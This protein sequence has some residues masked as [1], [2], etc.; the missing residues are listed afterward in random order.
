MVTGWPPPPRA[1]PFIGSSIHS[2]IHSP[3]LRVAVAPTNPGLSLLTVPADIYELLCTRH[4]QCRRKAKVKTQ[5]LPSVSTLVC[6]LFSAP[7]T[8]LSRVLVPGLCHTQ[9][10]RT[11]TA[12]CPPGTIDRRPAG[13]A[14][15]TQAHPPFVNLGKPCSQVVWVLWICSFSRSFRFSI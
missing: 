3:I 13:A 11:L 14:I 6:P 12:L 7:P 5:I 15:W 8:S 2:F 1:P 9:P 4:G 10:P